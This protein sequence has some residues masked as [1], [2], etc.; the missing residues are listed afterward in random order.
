MR[1]EQ[2]KSRHCLKIQS[3]FEYIKLEM[4]FKVGIMFSLKVKPFFQFLKVQFATY[5]QSTTTY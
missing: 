1:A 4:N 3:Y 5:P 2:V